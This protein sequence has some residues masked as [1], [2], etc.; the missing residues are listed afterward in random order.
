M[1]SNPR[2]RRGFTLVEMLVAM[3]ITM[4]L[5]F[6]LSQ[7]FAIVGQT[8]SEGRRPSKWPATCVRSGSGWRR[9][10]WA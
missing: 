10:C 5:I 8:V 7:A 2:R 6:A 1:H 3:T 9:T 4:I